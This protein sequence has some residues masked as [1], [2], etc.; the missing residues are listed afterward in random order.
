M[1]EIVSNIFA[2]FGNDNDNSQDKVMERDTLIQKM[3]ETCNV[4]INSTA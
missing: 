4:R 3:Q 2:E 1:E